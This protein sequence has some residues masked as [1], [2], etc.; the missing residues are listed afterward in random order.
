MTVPPGSLLR[1][2]CLAGLL[3]A[4]C[5][6]SKAPPPS[7]DIDETAYRDHL[8]VLSADDFEGRRPGSRGEEKTVAY[9][10]EQF[11]K[12]GLKPLADKSYVQAVPLL[13]VT[14]GEASAALL[15]KQGP[16]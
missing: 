1:L 16:L 14:V 6:G 10:T 8:R 7:T 5:T 4:A 12:L 15:G 9:L 11:R 13:E 2:A 3:L